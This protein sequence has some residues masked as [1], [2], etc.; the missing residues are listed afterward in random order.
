MKDMNSELTK[1]CVLWRDIM[2]RKVYQIHYGRIQ[3]VNRTYL[4]STFPVL[5]VFNEDEKNCVSP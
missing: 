3:S 1:H 2:Y 4:D 5:T